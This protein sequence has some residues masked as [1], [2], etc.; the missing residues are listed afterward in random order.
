MKKV[1]T[2]LLFFIIASTLTAC[3]V[4]TDNILEINKKEIVKKIDNISIFFDRDS[5]YVN[6]HYSSLIEDIAIFLSKNHNVKV[7]LNGY[8]DTMG[9]SE[10]NI[11]LGQRRANSVYE[12]MRILG[13]ANNQLEVV[14]FGKEKFHKSTDT[15]EKNMAKNRRVDILILN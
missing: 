12:I 3:S 9:S 2:I 4:I 15:L 6:N 7:I 1:F 8:A 14:S 13:V 5:Y 10:Y 11:A